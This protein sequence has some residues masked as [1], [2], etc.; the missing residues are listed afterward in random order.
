MANEKAPG[1]QDNPFHEHDCDA[2]I[3]LG[4][5]K[6]ASK[7]DLYYCPDHEEFV[8]RYGQVG[9]YYSAQKKLLEQIMSSTKYGNTIGN[10]Y[11]NE[12]VDRAIKAGLIQEFRI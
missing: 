6:G 3:F 9:D 8:A 2:C 12:A 5:Y 7:V 11:I 4:R 1:V 10:M